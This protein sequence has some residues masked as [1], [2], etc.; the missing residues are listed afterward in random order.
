LGLD[1]ERVEAAL[2]VLESRRAFTFDWNA[3]V[4]LDR[5]ALKVAPIGR[6]H[7]D[8]DD[9]NAET[10]LDKRIKGAVSKLR[11]LP[12]TP[13]LRELWK[14]AVVH[15]PQFAE[16][17]ADAFPSV[18]DDGASDGAFGDGTRKRLGTGQPACWAREES[19]V[20]TEVH[21]RIDGPTGERDSSD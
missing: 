13:L 21:T 20:S 5:D 16:A 7:I 14:V 2:R 3:A 1:R 18:A 15:S 11:E 4:V 6:R 19:N 10:K 8:A 9:W 17:I 12:S